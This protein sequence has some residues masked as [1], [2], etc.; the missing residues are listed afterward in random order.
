MNGLKDYVNA[1]WNSVKTFSSSPKTLQFSLKLSKTF[2]HIQMRKQSE[3][4]RKTFLWNCK[5]LE[6]AKSSCSYIYNKALW[7]CVCK[8]DTS[9]IHTMKNC[10]LS[11]NMYLLSQLNFLKSF[12]IFLLHSF[13]ISAGMI[14]SR[15]NKFMG[16][17]E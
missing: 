14:S 11:F 3:K 7:K 10:S 1:T 8:C 9:V 2:H 13:R 4:R 15:V 6:V 5:S 17:E 12:F 16:M